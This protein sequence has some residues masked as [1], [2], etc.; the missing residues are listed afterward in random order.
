[1][2]IK[3][4]LEIKEAEIVIAG[5][6]KLSMEIAEPIVNK[7]KTQAIPQVE[8]QKIKEADK[9][10]VEVTLAEPLPEQPSV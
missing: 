7:I 10:V 9:P 4:E 5:L 3:L 8:A 1:M 2:A 6:Y